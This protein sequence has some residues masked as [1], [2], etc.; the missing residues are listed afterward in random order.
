MSH[1]RLFNGCLQICIVGS[2]LSSSSWQQFICFLS[3]SGQMDGPS[4]TVTL[5]SQ[6]QLWFRYPCVQVL[7]GNK[8]L[9]QQRAAE[10]LVG[11]CSDCRFRKLSAVQLKVRGT[12]VGLDPL[13]DHHA[14]QRLDSTLL[15]FTSCSRR[16]RT[17]SKFEVWKT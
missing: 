10:F 4:T 8:I 9:S 16:G 1:Q 3:G 5:R 11:F 17:C 14:P 7:L 2:G 12:A 13:Q 6:K 15:F